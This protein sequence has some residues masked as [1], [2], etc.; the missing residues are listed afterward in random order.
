VLS[1]VGVACEAETRHESVLD[2][3][4]RGDVQSEPAAGPAAAAVAAIVA[5][6]QHVWGEHLEPQKPLGCCVRW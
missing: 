1:A 2:L 4:A 6:K 3:G 5:A